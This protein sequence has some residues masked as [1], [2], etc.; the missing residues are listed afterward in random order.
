VSLDARLR[1]DTLVV[2]HANRLAAA[3]A[4]AVAESPG[5]VYNPLVIYGASGLGK[6]HLLGAIAHLASA[7]HSALRWEYVSMLTFIDAWHAA[8]AAGA[9]AQWE[10]RWHAVELLLIDDI[11][12]LTGRRETQA[13]LMRLLE[14]MH[15]KGRQVVL[16]SDRPPSEI[17][18]MDDRLLARMQGGLIADVGRPDFETRAAILRAIAREREQGIAVALLDELAR[19]EFA[20]VRELHG[21]LNRL[22][23]QLA[24][25]DG[26]VSIAELAASLG[27]ALPKRRATTEDDFASFISEV[28]SVLQQ[29]VDTWRTRISDAMV[30]WGGLGYRTDVLERA[31]RLPEAPDTEGLLQTFAQ[32]VAHLQSLEAQAVRVEPSLAGASVFRDPERLSDAEDTVERA[33]SAALVLPQPLPEFRREDFDESGTNQLAVRAADAVIAGLGT[34][35]NPLLFCGPRGVGKSHLA[36][37]IAR[38]VLE[39]SGGRRRV[40]VLS[41]TALVDDLIVALREGRVERWR[42][43]YGTVDLLVLD[44]I[45]QLEGAERTQEELYLVCNTLL[46]AQR[47]LILTS[48]VPPRQ[49]STIDARLRSRFE[50]GLVVPLELPDRALRDRLAA[51]A[52]AAHG[53]PADAEL[54]RV[55]CDQPAATAAEL[56]AVVRTV[57]TAAKE[58]GVALT[59]AFAER[60]LSDGQRLSQRVRAIDDVDRT[61]LDPEK[62]IWEWPDPAARILEE[63]R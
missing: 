3:A 19:Y 6:T 9:T 12:F 40:A 60:V 2:G 42:R 4:R 17:A 27:V 28:T 61:F 58:A 10:A 5:R 45:E 39:R 48:A 35:Y 21:A 18:D 44:D 37:A 1:F 53:R 46:D 47:Q 33:V 52:L 59:A 24:L 57:V 36:H 62:V 63:I 20:N 29:H 51:R 43:R 14:G 7:Q 34:T 13:E 49:L 41:I 54:L 26:P 56:A 50:G 55:L 22:T 23:A 16:T 25:G 15:A 38:A 32:A 30:H 8:V 31:L 11:Q